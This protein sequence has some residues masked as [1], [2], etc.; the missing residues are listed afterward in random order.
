MAQPTEREIDSTA[1]SALVQMTGGVTWTEIPADIRDKYK[2]RRRNDLPGADKFGTPVQVKVS[3]TSPSGGP[4]FTSW[5]WSPE[6]P[7][8]REN[9]DGLLVPWSAGEE[10]PPSYAQQLPAAPP[11][12]LPT[13]E[14]NIPDG[15]SVQPPPLPD[16]PTSGTGTSGGEDSDDDFV[17]G[18]AIAAFA[19]GIFGRRRRRGSTL[20][21]TPQRRVQTAGFGSTLGIVA[22]VA[23]VGLAAYL[24][25]SSAT[26]PPPPP[27]RALP[28]GNEK[29]EDQEEG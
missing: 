2:F 28:R 16:E 23:G 21:T 17:F 8:A 10:R 29:R 13:G 20:P 15:G 3:A 11:L 7:A 1:F 18:Q 9:Q 12:T 26:R 24:V 22:L 6:F 19:T 27:R 5:I 14:I 25:T 4:R